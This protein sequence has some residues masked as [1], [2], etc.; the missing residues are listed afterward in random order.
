MVGGGRCELRTGPVRSLSAKIFIWDPRLI[1]AGL[2]KNFRWD[3]KT[4]K[5]K[6]FSETRGLSWQKIRVLNSQHPPLPLVYNERDSSQYT[7]LEWVNESNQPDHWQ[8]GIRHFAI[9]RDR[10]HPYQKKLTKILCIRALENLITFVYNLLLTL[11]LFFEHFKYSLSLSH[12]HTH[13]HTIA[14][15]S[16]K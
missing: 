10:V 12:T 5:I 15:G 2:F 16:L 8:F 14:M 7:A 1:L 6:G 11:F 3:P 4:C 13:T 9:V